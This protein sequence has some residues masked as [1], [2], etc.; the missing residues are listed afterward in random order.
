M[1][2]IAP[3]RKKQKN[4][5]LLPFI[6]LLCVIII[7]LIIVRVASASLAGQRKTSSVETSYKTSGEYVRDKKGLYELT[8]PVMD[9]AGVLTP[10]EK[11]E[12]DSFLRKV[13]KDYGVQIV[14]LTVQSLDG[15]SIEEFSINHAEK[16]QLGYKGVDNG[17][18][19]TVAMD[20]RDV[21]IET[22]YGTE[23]VLTDAI[24]SRIIRN[25]IIPS[26]RSGEYGKGIIE[27][28]KNMA[29]VIISDDSLISP[30]VNKD[31]VVY[32]QD[33]EYRDSASIV[34]A[35]IVVFFVVVFVLLGSGRRRGHF[36]FGPVYMGGPHYSRP[37]TDYD[38]GSHTDFGNHTNF[39]GGGGFSGGG[40]SFGGGGSSGH[41]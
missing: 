34:F 41:W 32:E 8:G 24:C 11:S 19:L 36:F 39:G 28:V 26:F 20:E 12:L 4:D 5:G 21:R 35:F 7:P 17:A 6:F 33:D 37:H 10:V 3:D 1:G 14:V 18:L 29:G 22:G 13:D 9:T 27:G 38:R 40:G 2:V 16:W 30:S 31:A 25:V 15:D 23:G